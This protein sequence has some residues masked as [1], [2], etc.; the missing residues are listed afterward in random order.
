MLWLKGEESSKRARN[1]RHQR[2]TPDAM[3]GR[4]PKEEVAG[5]PLGRASPDTAEVIVLIQA[6]GTF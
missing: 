6:A 5:A 2:L 1:L 3:L 4:L